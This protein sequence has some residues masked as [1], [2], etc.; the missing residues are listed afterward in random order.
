MPSPLGHAL[1]GVIGGWLVCGPPSMPRAKQRAS[2]SRAFRSSGARRSALGFG[3]L[4]V[5]ADFDFLFGTHSTYSHSIG[6]TLVV[7]VVALVWFAGKGTGSGSERFVASLAASAAYASHILL[8]WLGTD[9]AAPFGIMALWPISSEFH[10][11]GAGVFA[12]VERRFWL[13]DFWLRTLRMVASE[14][15]ILGVALAIV[16]R[17]RRATP[18]TSVD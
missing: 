5:L 16:W 1:G 13:P 7:F 8:D 15:V 17:T 10:L 9:G 4:G 18:R 2:F 3:L 14:V 12:P 6:A 11:A